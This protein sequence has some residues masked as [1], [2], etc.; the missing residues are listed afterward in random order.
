MSAQWTGENLTTDERMDQIR[1]DYV[2]NLSE[3]RCMEKQWRAWFGGAMTA[4]ALLSFGEWL[5]GSGSWS[6][7]AIGAGVVAIGMG[8]YR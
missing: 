1:V 7:G 5:S 4:T 3:I 6:A 2:Q 8:F